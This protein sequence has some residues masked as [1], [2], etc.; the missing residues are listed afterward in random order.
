MTVHWSTGARTRSSGSGFGS[1]DRS[2][3]PVRRERASRLPG[4]QRSGVARAGEG[5][6]LALFPTFILQP[7][8]NG[9]RSPSATT[10]ET[11]PMTLSGRFAISAAISLLAAACSSPTTPIS[12][13]GAYGLQLLE[14]A[15]LPAVIA[16][17]EQDTVYLLFVALIFSHDGV[18]TRHYETELRQPGRAPVRTL[19]EERFTYETSGLRVD[20]DYVCPPNALCLRTTDRGWYAP[21]GLVVNHRDFGAGTYRRMVSNLGS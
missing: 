7:R 17:E 3:L 8:G 13:V 12:P 5:V 14:G 16:T 1:S 9:L 10:D 20:I 11:H 15:A 6:T 21:G 2:P 18:G 4:V 19:H